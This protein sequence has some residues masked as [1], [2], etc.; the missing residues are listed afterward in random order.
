MATLELYQDDHSDDPPLLEGQMSNPGNNPEISSLGSGSISGSEAPFNTLD[1]P[2]R[3]TVWRDVKAVGTKFKHVLYP[4]QKKSLLKVSSI[5]K[6]PKCFAIIFPSFGLSHT[7]KAF[8]LLTCFVTLFSF[9]EHLLGT[10]FGTLFFLFFRRHFQ[11]KMV[12]KVCQK[13]VK[14][15]EPTLKKEVGT[16]CVSTVSKEKFAVKDYF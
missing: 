3:E 16:F 7:M 10:P 8:Y 9:L 11:K 1:E 5:D 4:V 12:K 13:K 15:C 2:I 14:W 6:C